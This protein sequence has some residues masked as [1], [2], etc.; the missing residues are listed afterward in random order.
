MNG[1]MLLHRGPI[2]GSYRHSEERRKKISLMSIGKPKLGI[3]GENHHRWRGEDVS[4]DALHHWV[5]RYLLQ[6]ELCEHCGKVPPKH[7]ACVTG[8]YSRDFSNW[9]YL[10]LSCHM[11]LDKGKDHSNTRCSQCGSTDTYID[12]R[13][14]YDR[15]IWRIS[16]ITNEY[17]C[18]KCEGR[19]R[20][21]LHEDKE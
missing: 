16:K 20:R 6:P 3:R 13:R 19:E 9:K 17:F 10:C 1:K 2:P 21:V 4:I 18:V 12:R 15:P 5:K 8:D 14:G 11:R 7:L